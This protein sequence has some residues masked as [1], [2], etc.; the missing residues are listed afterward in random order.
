MREILAGPGASPP[1]VSRHIVD[2]AH[3]AETKEVLGAEAYL[4]VLGR[5]KAEVDQLISWLQQS[6]SM[7]RT[8]IA[9]EVHK[10]AGNAALFGAQEMRDALL[11]IENAA[12]TGSHQDVE[13]GIALLPDIW[14]RS[15]AALAEI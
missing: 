6:Q 10:I 13:Q 14:R 1:K 5:F 4:K 3:N 12:K 7:D 2:L 15:K 8:D 9:A 11:H